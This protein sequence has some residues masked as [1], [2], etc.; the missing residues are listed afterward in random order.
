MVTRSCSASIGTVMEQNDAE[1]LL[2]TMVKPGT[3]NRNTAYLVTQLVSSDQVRAVAY[4][5]EGLITM[6]TAEMACEQMEE[7]FRRQSASDII[8]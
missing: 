4:A 5:K 3:A 7:A 1:Q 8:S 6:H 2:V